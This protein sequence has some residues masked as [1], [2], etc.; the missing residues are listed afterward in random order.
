MKVIVQTFKL[1]EIDLGAVLLVALPQP[2]QA[3]KHLGESS[4]SGGCLF[5]LLQNL[6]HFLYQTRA[7][8]VVYG[9]DV[10]FFTGKG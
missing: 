6:L 9:N 4:V 3:L 1:Q 10:S 2:P 8:S 7:I 5:C